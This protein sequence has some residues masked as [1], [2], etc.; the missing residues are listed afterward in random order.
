M[1][2]CI[3]KIKYHIFQSMPPIMKEDID[4]AYFIEGGKKAFRECE[5]EK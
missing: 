1:N 2:P 5:I 4:L 3:S